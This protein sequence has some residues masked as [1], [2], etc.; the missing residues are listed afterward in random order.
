MGRFLVGAFVGAIA[1]AL[2]SVAVLYVADLSES[3]GDADGDSASVAVPAAVGE[4]ASD[5]RAAVEAVGLHVRIAPQWALY[6][7]T[8]EAES[9]LSG[10]IVEQTPPAGTEVPPDAT[11]TLDMGG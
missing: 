10:V 5:A 4:S 9:G 7:T 6:E 11:V 1:V 2:V 8:F 3:D